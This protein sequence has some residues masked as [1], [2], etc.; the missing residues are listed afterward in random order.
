MKIL[1]VAPHLSTGGMPQYLYKQISYFYKEHQIEV[2]DYTNS[3]GKEYVVQKERIA[4]LVPVHNHSVLQVFE[5]FSPDI[6]HFQE[7]PE[8]FLPLDV[9]KVLFA[10]DRKHFNIATPHSSTVN[11]DIIHYHPDKYVFVCK[12]SLNKFAHLGIDS[13]VWT[14]PIERQSYYSDVNARF[15]LGFREDSKHVLHVGL[16]TP[17]KN[18]GEIFEIA[19]Q[20][21]H[22]PI[23][24]HFVGNQ[25][26]NFEHYWGPLMKNKPSNCIIWGERDDVEIFYKAA[27]LFY[28]PS[29]FELYPISLLEALSYNIPCMF[30][31][32][33]SYLDD[34]DRENVTYIGENV[35]EN[36]SLLLKTLQ[37]I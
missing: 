28:F 33:P 30:R 15:K 2:V 5:S 37:L 25:A 16:F 36:K 8:H 18:Q 22:L 31:K 10:P 14:Y 27:H 1:Y 20:I 29:K 26:P 17:G 6:V 12:W 32:L 9:L 13:D 24:F 19:R 4:S 34:F 21:E 23:T 7:I 35:T 11:P 3:G